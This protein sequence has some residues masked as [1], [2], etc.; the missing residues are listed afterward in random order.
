MAKICTHCRSKVRTE[1]DKCPS[2]GGSEFWYK[3]ANCG[4]VFNTPFCPVC[5]IKAGEQPKNC[6]KCGKQ[7]FTAS[8]PNCGWN[9][10]HDAVE[11]TLSQQSQ[12]PIQVF[13]SAPTAV[14]TSKKK[15]S[16]W[17]ILLWVFFLPIMGCIAIAKSQRLSKKWKIGLITGIAA[18]SIII[19]TTGQTG[20]KEASKEAL[21]S[22]PSTSLVA[23]ESPT[24]KPIENPA[25]IETAE[26]TQTTIQKGNR[27]PVAL[28]LRIGCVLGHFLPRGVCALVV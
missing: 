25:V 19:G 18:L 3:C 27:C 1:A 5:G 7:Y 16:I 21:K 8:C 23:T 10:A 15:A 4:K 13:Q 22:L 28:H 11:R 24:E 14:R 26:P 20:E 17:I 6:P 2:C 9:P 12:R